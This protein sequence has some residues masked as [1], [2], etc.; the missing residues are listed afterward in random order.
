MNLANPENM[1]M[2]RPPGCALFAKISP[3]QPE[4]GNSPQVAFLIREESRRI[5]SLSGIVEVRASLILQ[6]RVGLVPILLQVAEGQEGIFETWLNY[7]AKD[8]LGRKDTHLETLAMQGEIRILFYGRSGR[9]RSIMISNER[10]KPTW[11][12]ILD[13]VSRMPEWG[14]LDFDAAREK[15]YAGCPTVLDLWKLLSPA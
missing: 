11:N 8:A 3:S 10:L 15:V 7:F 9:E 12:A 4:M 6:E 5:R 13:K 2:M 14:M 1:I